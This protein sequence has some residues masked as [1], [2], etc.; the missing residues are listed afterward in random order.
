[1]LG[2]GG[3]T[4]RKVRIYQVDAFSDR[5]FGGNPAGVVPEAEGLSETEMQKIAREMNLSETAFVFDLRPH[6]RND[7][8]KD[9]IG[10]PTTV[11][12]PGEA[13]PV[14]GKLVKGEAVHGELMEGELRG[15]EPGA[16]DPAKKGSDGEQR[17]L[18]QRSLPERGFAADGGD[19]P[20]RSPAT[21]QVGNKPLKQPSPD[22][23]VRFFT[24]QTEVDLCGHAT[25]GTF[26]LLA[27]EGWIRP[28][29]PA[30]GMDRKPAEWV[31]GADLANSGVAEAWSTD[32]PGRKKE[33]GGDIFRQRPL[34]E[35]PAW[36]GPRDDLPPPPTVIYQET[37]AGLLPVEIHWR[38]AQ[39]A[40]PG[41]E[42]VVKDGPWE[43]RADG[44]GL[45]KEGP[46]GKGLYVVDRVMMHQR[47]PEFLGRVEDVA[48][49]AEI[50]GLAAEEIGVRQTV[51]SR[52]AIAM[53]TSAVLVDHKATKREAAA[54]EVTLVKMPVEIV[55]TGLPDLIVPVVSQ[56]ALNRMKP[57]LNRLKAYCERLGVISVH[58]FW[59]PPAGKV[60]ALSPKVNPSADA[61]DATGLR[62]A[63]PAGGQEV[64]GPDI[65]PGI[66][67]DETLPDVDETEPDAICRDFA[68]AVGIPEE[69]A[70][71]TASG[72]LGAY[73]V[74]HGVLPGER[75]AGYGQYYRFLFS[76]GVAMG[77]PSLIEVE[78]EVATP[79]KTGDAPTGF[80]TGSVPETGAYE[81]IV[82]V[83]VGGRA[84][85]VIE[86]WVWMEDNPTG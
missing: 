75:S 28:A 64:G 40:F 31:K 67:V 49:L 79:E 26:F 5:P 10:K 80:H 9:G 13:E 44:K 14:K 38:P 23:R 60:P 4:L 81:N 54:G 2:K 71:G 58:A 7:P 82:R 12:E 62:S 30:E 56:E 57:D 72:A 65:G 51:G 73:L 37:K 74:A 78:V 33:A 53:E 36:P 22:F 17:L 19:G 20:A 61:L 43:K 77:R 11:A 18:A 27:E 1:V 84:V 69:A 63:D 50:L 85:K 42:A 83:K 41:D 15:T 66:G 76:Q 16:G 32:S 52:P 70:T 35:R 55:S 24:P 86:G 46:S 25:I 3:W 68:P 29:A 48:E 21:D 45:G 34:Q 47:P 6:G 8:G 39:N 59:L